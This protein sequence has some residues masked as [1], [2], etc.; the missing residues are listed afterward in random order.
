MILKSGGLSNSKTNRISS[1]GSASIESKFA[2]LII[3]MGHLVCHV[4]IA[5]EMENVKV[6]EPGKAMANALVISVTPR[7]IVISVIMSI[8]KHSEMTRNYYVLDVTQLAMIMDVLV[9]DQRDAEP[10]S[11]VSFSFSLSLLA[12]HF[13]IS[14]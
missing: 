14:Y 2:V 12:A 6:T 5:L 3:R 11:Q 13:S 4:P 9:L 8:M 7:K 1:N 10:V